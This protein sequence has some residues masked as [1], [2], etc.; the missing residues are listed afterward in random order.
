MKTDIMG[1]YKITNTLDNKIY[2]GSAHNITVRWN[3]HKRELRTNTHDNKYIQTVYN[4]IGDGNFLYE[5]I[6]K[7]EIEETLLDV[8]Q[9]W[10]DNT[11]SYNPEFGYNLSCITRGSN[12]KYS[13]IRQNIVDAILQETKVIPLYYDDNCTEWITNK[14]NIIIP[15]VS[16]LNGLFKRLYEFYDNNLKVG[17]NINLSS[18]LIYSE[19]INFDLKNIIESNTNMDTFLNNYDIGMIRIEDYCHNSNSL[20]INKNSFVW[21]KVEN[22]KLILQSHYRKDEIYLIK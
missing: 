22:N 9:K 14:G 16:N 3:T 13:L 15:V 6:E 5:I 1:I 7:V 8:E 2:I 11:Q 10:L 20:N 4:K 21:F 17:S 19:S 12:V 18:C